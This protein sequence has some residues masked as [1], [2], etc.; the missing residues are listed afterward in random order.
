MRVPVKDLLGQSQVVE[1]PDGGTV[2]HLV[3]AVAGAGGSCRLYFM[4]RGGGWRRKIRRRGLVPGSTQ[5]TWAQPPIHK[6]T[7]C[8]LNA[9]QQQGAE[10]HPS[11]SL[12]DALTDLG[13]C[14]GSGHVVSDWK[15]AF[16]QRNTTVFRAN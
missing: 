16:V 7:S 11:Q 1:L 13:T 2:Q 8:S 3:R 14:S 10:L 4:V 6:Y 15:V 12:A 5:P 9:H